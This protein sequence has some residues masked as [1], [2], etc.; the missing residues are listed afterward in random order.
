MN[1]RPCPFCGLSD[2][3]QQHT[4]VT[5]CTR[6]KVIASSKI[7]NQRPIEDELTRTL[8]EAAAQGAY[9]PV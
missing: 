2:R 8:D 4:L 5:E 9:W 3:V 1:P 6:C 7:W